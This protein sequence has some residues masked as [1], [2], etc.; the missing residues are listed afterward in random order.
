M[1]DLTSFTF[2]IVTYQ[3]FFDQNI[4]LCNFAQTSLNRHE[5]RATNFEQIENF[6]NRDAAKGGPVWGFCFKQ[7]Q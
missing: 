5:Y 1:H 4:V 6:R 7:I 3:F 2:F